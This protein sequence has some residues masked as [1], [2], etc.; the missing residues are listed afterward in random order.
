MLG[1]LAGIFDAEGNF[2]GVI[3]IANTDQSIIDWTCWCLRRL[4]FAHVVERLADRPVQNVRLTGGLGPA[5]R[6]FQLTDPA[7]GRKR[8]IEGR[9]LESYEP[10]RRPEH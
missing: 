3:R 6:F 2:G 5:M 10:S 8:S 1:F 9:A 4:G 7:I